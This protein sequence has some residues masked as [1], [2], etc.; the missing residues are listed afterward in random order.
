MCVTGQAH[1]KMPCAWEAQKQKRA[2][3][4]TLGGGSG[5]HAPW[6]Q[7]CVDLDDPLETGR[8]CFGNKIFPHDACLQMI[9][10]LWGIVV[11]PVYWGTPPLWEAHACDSPTWHYG[12]KGTRSQSQIISDTS[13]APF[14]KVDNTRVCPPLR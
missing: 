2:S 11:T 13:C 12:M 1:L 10:A 5:K 3:P 14:F 9:I 4:K 8:G 7:A 6:P